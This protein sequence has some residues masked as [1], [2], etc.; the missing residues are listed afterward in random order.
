M[1]H[2]VKQNNVTEIIKFSNA[3]FRTKPRDCI[4]YSED[5]TEFKIHRELLGQTEFMRE[6]LK[7]V[8]DHCCNE[9]EIICPCTK[10]EMEKL[11]HF[12]YFGELHCEDIFE[13]FNLQEDLNKV[14]GFSENLILDDRTSSLM[15]NSSMPSIIDLTDYDLDGEIIEQMADE[16]NIYVDTLD[17]AK[18]ESKINHVTKNKFISENSPNYEGF[19]NQREKPTDQIITINPEI[20]S[21]VV[22]I[23]NDTLEKEQEIDMNENIK[24]KNSDVTKN[25][26]LDER[27][28]KGNIFSR[29]LNFN[30]D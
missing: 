7:S 16:M 3:Y 1:F 20:N 18:K 23:N 26:I 11:V 24:S 28:S 13:S 25:T 9:L 2:S 8:K 19:E 29:M 30:T 4:L 22:V 17:P 21:N 15:G 5:K 14:F 12:L 10:E 27:I 6:I